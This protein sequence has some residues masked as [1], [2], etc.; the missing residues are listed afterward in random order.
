MTLETELT[1][2]RA[3]LASD[4]AEAEAVLA[5][6]KATLAETIATPVLASEYTTH[7]KY[8]MARDCKNE[9]II[10]L[11]AI[12]KNAELSL[13]EYRSIVNYDK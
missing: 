4:I 10:H 11:R 12:I 3:R 5:N 6:L 7:K 9:A 1:A 8:E 2:S 13:S